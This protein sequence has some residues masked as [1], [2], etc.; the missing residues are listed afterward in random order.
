MVM[1]GCAGVRPGERVVRYEDTD[2][3]NIIYEQQ[4]ARQQQL[5]EAEQRQQ[6]ETRREAS[7]LLPC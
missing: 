6:R 3:G 7:V 5:K 1:C 2:E 4:L